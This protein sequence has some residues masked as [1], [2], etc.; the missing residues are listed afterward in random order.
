MSK[1]ITLIAIGDPAYG[2]FAF[3]M[4]MSIKAFNKIPIQLICEPKTIS[5]LSPWHLQFFDVFTEV[6]KE[7]CYDGQRLNPGRLKLKL[8][9][10]LF[11]DET[12]YLDVD[13]L[14]I[15]N[16]D[17]IWEM[18]E[19]GFYHTQVVG[20]HE[21]KSYEDKFE[22]IQWA[23]ISDMIK[24]YHLKPGD[25]IPGINSSFQYIKKDIQTENLYQTA[26]KN[27][28]N[29]IPKS[30]RPFK[31]GKDDYEP[32]ELYMNVALAQIGHNPIMKNPLVIYFDQRPMKITEVERDFCFVGL[33][34]GRLF[35]HNTIQSY[36]DKVIEKISV[37]Y[38]NKHQDFKIFSLMKKKIST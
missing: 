17:W 32:D 18:C 23:S 19:G 24:Y 11:F 3:N 34:G 37:D 1:G 22:G 31:W 16:F 6:K 26:M 12:I 35:T 21:I 33:Y 38:H 27:F 10:Y 20:T 9:N 2:K 28:E 36:Y 4:A 25:V 30:Q 8:Y 7:D 13:G 29:P 15:K 5:H 14:C